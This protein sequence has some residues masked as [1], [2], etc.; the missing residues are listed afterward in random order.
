MLKAEKVVDLNLTSEALPIPGKMDQKHD[1][2]TLQIVR[3]IEY[4]Y[5][6]TGTLYKTGQ[7]TS[8]K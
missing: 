1:C 2:D 6:C 8:N 7:E 5:S 3:R 4:L